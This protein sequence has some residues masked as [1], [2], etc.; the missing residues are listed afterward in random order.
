MVNN[1]KILV[2]NLGFYKSVLKNN[3]KEENDILLKKTKKK[4]IFMMQ[5]PEHENLGDHAIVYAQKEFV[6]NILPS[7]DIVEIPLSKVLSQTKNLKKII[8]ND[9]I[10]I[11]PGGGNMGDLYIGEEYIRRYIIK[12]FK[13]NKI[14]SFPQTIC[15][16]E[17]S[18]G[19]KE[20][21]KSKKVY[22]KHNNI[23]IVAREKKSYKIMT[24]TFKKDNIILTPDIVLFLDK[25]NNNKR[26]GIVTCLRRDIEKNISEE[27]TKKI[28]SILN[29]NFEKVTVTDTILEK[30]VSIEE[31]DKELT[32]IWRTISSAEVVITDR[33]HGMIF[34]AITATPCI[35]LK[36]SNHKIEESY[37]CWLKDLEYIKLIDY[38][39]INNLKDLVE[40]LKEQNNKDK[41]FNDCKNKFEDLKKALLL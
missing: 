36:N 20:L 27:D 29:E 2:K 17:T 28:Y 15:F 13:N 4:K 8:S 31:R 7:Y 19:E 14:I 21:S 18:Y 37:K 41:V 16:T 3:F 25:R 30:S 40:S 35:V 5:T 10:I 12:K 11:I 23:K 1:I 24:N 34:C 22:N 9:D 33:L 39:E 38:C 6:K 26:R 32:K